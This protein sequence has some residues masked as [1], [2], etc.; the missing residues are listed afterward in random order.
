MA[1]FAV[2][3]RPVHMYYNRWESPP[4]SPPPF[5]YHMSPHVHHHGCMHSGPS[6]KTR[7]DLLDGSIEGATA[8]LV[9]QILQRKKD[10]TTLIQTLR[11]RPRINSDF[12][13]GKAFHYFR[14]HVFESPWDVEMRANWKYSDSQDTGETL[15]I[16]DDR[17][18]LGAL[19]VLNGTVLCNAST[20]DRLAI[21]LHHMIHGF[22]L[23]HTHPGKAS[24]GEDR[25][26]HGN[27]FGSILYALKDVSA[28]DKN[29][30][31]QP[32]PLSFGHD[33][34]NRASLN[35]PY[36][37]RFNGT[38]PY[39]GVPYGHNQM[40]CT[41]CGSDVQPISKDDCQKWYNEKC[42]PL[43]DEVYIYKMNPDSELQQLERRH[44][45]HH[46]NDY[47]E[48]VWDKKHIYIPR[49][50]VAQYSSTLGSQFNDKRVVKLPGWVKKD[51]FKAL[52]SFLTDGTYSPELK[53]AQ[54]KDS[55]ASQ[56]SAPLMREFKKDFP[57]Y[58][59]ID[60]K[61]YKLGRA[62]KFDE[63]CQS[64]LK[65]LESLHFTHENVVS[66]LEEIYLPSPSKEKD[67]SK[68]KS[69]KS[70]EGS[71]D[72][73]SSSSTPDEELR[74][75]ARAFFKR[76]S[77]HASLMLNEEPHESSNIHR[78]MQG[79]DYEFRPQFLRLLEKQIPALEEDIRRAKTEFILGDN[80][81]SLPSSS[82]RANTSTNNG[83]VGGWGPN[84]NAEKQIHDHMP[85]S[86]WL[87]KDQLL[88]QAMHSMNIATYPRGFMPVQSP[89]A[90]PPAFSAMGRDMN[91][92]PMVA[93][94][95]MMWSNYQGK[96]VPVPMHNLQG[97]GLDW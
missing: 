92:I 34:Q 58:M 43:L 19:T 45:A 53:K 32:L 29:D 44:L 37:D 67:D 94:T 81:P 63:L 86:D 41:G 71:K 3:D 64:A 16:S 75:F 95:R 24:D 39:P 79:K 25:Y 84:V 40:N 8:F 11:N 68:S 73:S 59:V 91:G 74:A 52:F 87:T 23:C 70:K 85:L 9:D 89:P 65:R 42:Q 46:D 10:I 90:S 62:L 12:L 69:K 22:L 48:F 61:M 4:P 77:P 60:I 1:R 51:V 17:G 26:A 7:R 76:N 55:N 15:E 6:V 14:K 28:G 20:D 36:W 27:A 54:E 96:W 57:A 47:F 21:L 83:I 38:S 2:G 56:F 82:T 93:N 80:T 78:L 49:S 30:K 88:A 13:F 72:G 97:M 33:L 18:F 66:A 31:N 5:Q 50:A 35:V